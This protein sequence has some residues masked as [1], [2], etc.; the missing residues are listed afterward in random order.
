MS[1]QLSVS[2]ATDKAFPTVLGQDLASL[3]R[4][5]PGDAERLRK[6]AEDLAFCTR[7]VRFVGGGIVYGFAVV[8]PRRKPNSAAGTDLELDGHT[9]YVRYLYVVPGHRS[10][11]GI[12]L[13]FLEDLV[14][15]AQQSD[16]VYLCFDLPISEQL[17]RLHAVLQSEELFAWHKLRRGEAQYAI[18]YTCR[19][20]DAA[21]R[22]GTLNR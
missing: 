8:H 1:F 6:I 14:R 13:R 5:A 4:E 20:A 3:Q 2:Y 15:H 19:L 16:H 12:L 21:Q 22:L 7:L 11:P 17:R 9:F 18:R 10:N